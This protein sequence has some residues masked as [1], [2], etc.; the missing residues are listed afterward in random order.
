MGVV[1]QDK[2]L[3][4]FVE[5]E[6]RRVMIEAFVQASLES[7]EPPTGVLWLSTRQPRSHAIWLLKISPTMPPNNRVG[8]SLE[9][10]PSIAFSR[11]LRLITG[12][13]IDLRGAL[14]RDEVLAQAVAAGTP[15]PV[16][17]PATEELQRFARRLIRTRVTQ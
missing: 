3:M 15:V 11:T 12:R 16:P 17:T 7:H 8:E 9:L 14:D 6:R 4:K 5:K 1:S 2:R 13:L 10:L